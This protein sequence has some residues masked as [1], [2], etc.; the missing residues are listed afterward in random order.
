[1][2]TTNLASKSP[3]DQQSIEKPTKNPVGRPSKWSIDIENK[4]TRFLRLGESDTLV[5]L[6]AGI[7]RTNYYDKLK[8]RPK[9]ARKVAESKEYANNI[10]RKVLVTSMRRD[11]DTNTAKWWLERK[12]PEEFSGESTQVNILQQFN[13]NNDTDAEYGK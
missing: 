9:F 4:I 12:V 11:K 6:R 7:D 10:A 13:S 3:P 8:S 2:S 1:M 5:C